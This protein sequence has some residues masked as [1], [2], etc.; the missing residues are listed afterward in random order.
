MITVMEARDDLFRKLII[1]DLQRQLPGVP[2][3]P[4]DSL[5][6]SEVSKLLARASM[7]ALSEDAECRTLAYEIA[8]RIVEILGNDNHKALLAADSVLSRLGNFPGR[9]LLRT[10][11][12]VP[13]NKSAF[14]ALE[15][16]ARES[17]NLTEG[18][19]SPLTDF[20][21]DFYKAISSKKST[22]ISAPTSAG[23]SFV[24]VLDILR[25]LRAG[26]PTSIV[27]VVPTRALIRQVMRRIGQELASVGATGTALRCV[28]LPATPE[29]VPDGIVYVLTQ[30]RLMSLLYSE[31]G[32]AW[33]TTLIV[34]EAQGV[35][36]GA[37]G[38][39]LQTAIDTVLARFPSVD[40]IFASP[41]SR[42][43]EYL[44]DLFNRNIFRESFVERHSPVSQNRILVE[45]G[46]NR[47]VKFSVLNNDERIELGKRR[48]E[49]FRFSDG[50]SVCRARLA[51]LV[52]E[53]NTSTIIYENGASAAES[54]AISLAGMLN[55]PVHPDDEIVEFI[56]F[57][58]EH[59]HAEYPL[60][61]ALK[62]DV[63][64]HFGEMPAIV[65]ARIEDLVAA[66]KLKYVACTSTLLQ[67]VNLPAKNIIIEKPKKGTRSD[68]GKADFENLAGR[69]GR[70]IKEFHG[71]VWCVRPSNW[72]NDCIGGES[73]QVITSAFATVFHN[74][75]D[76]V[77]KYLT[78]PL[79][80]TES[81]RDLAG[82]VLGKYFSEYILANRNL[83]D[84]LFWDPSQEEKLVSLETQCRAIETALPKEIF[85]RNST[86]SP[87]QLES[88]R[89]HFLQHENPR[90]C[91]PLLW[92][93]DGAYDRLLNIFKLVWKEL[94][95]ETNNSYIYHTKLG[96]D[97][98]MGAPL[99]QMIARKIERVSA[100][101][102][103]RRPPADR[104]VG[105][106]IR[107][108]M[109]EV[110]TVLRYRYVKWL[111]AYNDVLHFVLKE[112]DL[113]GDEEKL[114]PLHL[115]L[116]CG[117]S[118]RVSLSLIALG[119]SRTTALLLKNK[120]RFP[121]DCTPEGCREILRSINLSQ[122]EISPLCRRELAEIL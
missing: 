33:I 41:L 113:V 102:I 76:V 23:K 43:P 49:N 96:W 39:I 66:N 99:K 119:L 7:L 5:T 121:E 45:S 57:L 65:R 26:R 60:I 25:R 111:K 8:T 90:T 105:V 68:M 116:E 29:D 1:I 51:K 89:K 72:N 98:M 53:A 59:I 46:G 97:W 73:L 48:I 80:L 44:L 79:E 74:G 63:A 78:T 103:S 87:L 117:A 120:V 9:G 109:H 104:L 2:I 11:Y 100:D 101:D 55:A 31:E 12:S 67:G 107:K 112:R 61:E 92:A 71:N 3:V 27:Y 18:V 14:F 6:D 30:E 47:A 19:A 36:D 37:R 77:A 110:E 88:L 50:G 56:E 34:D 69:A 108:L 114:I 10:R 28:P 15:A 40:V 122:I 4:I 52:T 20:Q 84:T 115:F 70:L 75:G 22:S 24:L 64:F 62:R 42:N 17:E 94:G 83:R 21:I 54:T 95:G 35:K 32:D 13:E 106:S 81:E 38:V 93:Q 86:I 91:L 85:T 16:I 58:T 82:T 118:D